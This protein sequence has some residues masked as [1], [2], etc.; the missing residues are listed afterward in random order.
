MWAPP[1]A[2]EG[3]RAEEGRDFAWAEEALARADWGRARPSPEL[4]DVPGPRL[5]ASAAVCGWSAL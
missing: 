5:A 4:R 3:R 2:D 1:L